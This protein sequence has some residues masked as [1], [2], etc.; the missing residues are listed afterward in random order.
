MSYFTTIQIFLDGK[1]R[2]KIYLSDVRLEKER[3]AFPVNMPARGA[4]LFL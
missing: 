1:R 2:T 4:A 3:A